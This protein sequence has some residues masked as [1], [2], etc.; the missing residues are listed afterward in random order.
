MTY[1]F[2]G[3]GE[4]WLTDLLQTLSEDDYTIIQRD[5]YAP[6]PRLEPSVQPVLVVTKRELQGLEPIPEVRERW[7]DRQVIVQPDPFDVNDN[8][9]QTFTFSTTDLQLI[10][11][12]LF[13]TDGVNSGNTVFVSVTGMWLSPRAGQSEPYAPQY[14]HFQWRVYHA[15]G[16]SLIIPAELGEEIP[17]PVYTAQDYYPAL[18]GYRFRPSWA[19]SAPTASMTLAFRFRLQEWQGYSPYNPPFENTKFI[20][21]PE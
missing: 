14:L 11:G 9:M 3:H 1:K 20:R 7:V 13:G 17:L 2:V 15:R 18:Y 21:L 16:E 19:G 10:L 5:Q 4:D 6:G 8:A 12:A